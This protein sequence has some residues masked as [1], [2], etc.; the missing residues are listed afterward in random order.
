MTHPLHLSVAKEFT[1]F[2]KK[3]KILLDPACGGSQNLPFF[4][5]R[6]KSNANKITNVD[7]V[8]IVNNK[9]KVVCEIDE[10]NIKPGHIYGKFLSLISTDICILKNGVE[11]EFDE[12]L[13]FVQVLST[14]NLKKKSKKEDQ[15]GI[16]ENSIQSNLSSFNGKKI[17]YHILIGDSSSF[18][19]SLKLR[20]IIAGLGC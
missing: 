9:V 14:E 20:S 2:A 15:W 13:I 16:I 19:D 4:I 5:G 11:Y 3:C 18:T 7:L 17:K 6:P 12:E 10:S 1:S 8:V